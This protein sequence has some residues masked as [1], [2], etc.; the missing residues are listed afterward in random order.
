MTLVANIHVSY[1]Q[2]ANV[3]RANKNMQIPDNALN[4]IR[5]LSD[6]MP[7]ILNFNSLLSTISD[8]IDP[9]ETDDLIDSSE[10]GNLS[11]VDIGVIEVSVPRPHKSEDGA[12]YIVDD[13]SVPTYQSFTYLKSE[14]ETDDDFINF[15]K[16]EDLGISIFYNNNGDAVISTSMLQGSEKIT[17][18]ELRGCVLAKVH[19]RITKAEVLAK[20]PPNMAS[21]ITRLGIR[22]PSYLSW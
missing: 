12:L 16:K 7:G 4:H 1:N 8:S 10:W 21:L 18:L 5:A 17:L 9:G 20:L 2:Y 11:I 3:F 14:S 19:G 22:L 6:C 15:L 13:D